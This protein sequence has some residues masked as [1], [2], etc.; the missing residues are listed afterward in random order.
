MENGI[1]RTSGQIATYYTP[2]FINNLPV[3]NIKDLNCD[4]SDLRK[5]NDKIQDTLEYT[6]EQFRKFKVSIKL[7]EKLKDNLNNQSK[8]TSILVNNVTSIIE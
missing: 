8:A 6:K 3:N 1:T 4:D 2:S 5:L 7:G